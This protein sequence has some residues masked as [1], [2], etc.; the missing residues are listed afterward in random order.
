MYGRTVVTSGSSTA[1]LAVH[2]IAGC[3]HVANLLTGSL[4]DS[5]VYSESPVTNDSFIHFWRAEL[6][7]CATSQQMACLSVCLSHVVCHMLKTY[8]RRIIQFS[9]HA[10]PGTLVFLFQFSYC[11]SKGNPC[12]RASSETGVGK[13]CENTNFQPLNHSDLETI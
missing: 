1:N 11:G 12:A 3:C 2:P 5:L 10:S 4:S 13:N 7:Q 8:D 9:P 6:C